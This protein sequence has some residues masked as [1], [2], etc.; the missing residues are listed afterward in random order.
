MS[1]SSSSSEEDGPVNSNRNFIT[2]HDLDEVEIE[3]V[4]S[5]MTREIFKLAGRN[6]TDHENCFDA[7][8]QM[9]KD[10]DVIH[11]TDFKEW[12]K[13][14]YVQAGLDSLQTA[15]GP[16]D[17]DISESV[18]V[19]NAPVAVAA[20]ATLNL[21]RIHIQKDSRLICAFDKSELWGWIGGA[22]DY[23]SS[24]PGP[25]VST[26]PRGTIIHLLQVIDMNCDSY[27]G[28]PPFY[29]LQSIT[30][31]L[32]IHLRISQAEIPDRG[33]HWLQNRTFTE[34]S[35]TRREEAMEKGKE[36][37]AKLGSQHHN[38]A[39][40]SL[41]INRWL[42][43]SFIRV[44]PKDVKN[45][46]WTWSLQ[47]HS[48]WQTT[49]AQATE[50]L[51]E[52]YAF[53]RTREVFAR[54][55]S[56]DFQQCLDPGRCLVEALDD[57]VSRDIL[58]K[59]AK[60]MRDWISLKD[61][62]ICY[63]DR[64]WK[65]M[66]E[67]LIQNLSLVGSHTG[68][69]GKLFMGPKDKDDRNSLVRVIQQVVDAS[70]CGTPKFPALVDAWLVLLPLMDYTLL[71][72]ICFDAA[73]ARGRRGLAKEFPSSKNLDEEEFSKMATLVNHIDPKSMLVAYAVFYSYMPRVV[74]RKDSEL[75]E[76]C[77]ARHKTLTTKLRVK[78]RQRTDSES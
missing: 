74:R 76:R 28:Q 13:H 60:N 68:T 8:V 33:E 62:Q 53:S 27:Q 72:S 77:L 4:N 63:A 24:L 44:L 69:P 45:K 71:P 38:Q 16:E 43:E 50:D 41:P 20:A 2:V 47:H 30:L 32:F 10:T 49:I 61:P 14:R 46:L 9:V 59:L 52:H 75:L 56:S 21:P 23:W 39:F 15:Q 31:P 37:L 36:V 26:L 1:S 65:E 70:I 57:K 6:P 78:K 35:V 40:L 22:I 42:T 3:T 58:E 19:M 29:P 7:C 66:S 17:P 34:F 18:W 25:M 55:A 5:Q 11:A 67:R 48:Q 51:T 73:R 64:E 54:L 12:E